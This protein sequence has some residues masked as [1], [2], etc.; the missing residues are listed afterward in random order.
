MEKLRV[1]TV[2][3]QSL[4]TL[5]KESKKAL[6]IHYINVVLCSGQPLANKESQ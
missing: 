5:V 6:V 4:R 3:T 1:E 2:P